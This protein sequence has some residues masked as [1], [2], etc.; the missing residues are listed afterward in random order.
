MQRIVNIVV[1]G[2]MAIGLMASAAHAQFNEPGIAKTVKASVVTGYEACTTPN[3]TTSDSTPACTAVRSDPVC[4][5]VGG[6]HGLMYIRTK[7]ATGWAVKIVLLGLGDPCKDETI[8][9]FATLRTTTNDCGAG[10][11]CTVDTPNVELGS[12]VVSHTGKCGISTPVFA[13]PP[14]IT[15]SGGTELTDLKG[16]RTGAPGG[17]A[18]FR[19][20]IVNPFGS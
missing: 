13:T 20:G 2:A 8:H 16:V 18:A 5:F 3:T 11:P 19:I 12:C 9:F 17:K 14:I 1:V 6:G 15:K 4:G 7:S 10:S